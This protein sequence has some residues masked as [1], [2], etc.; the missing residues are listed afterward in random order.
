M[1]VKIVTENDKT[2]AKIDFHFAI[3][4][5]FRIMLQMRTG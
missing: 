4:Q 5:Y 3:I 2:A 1:L